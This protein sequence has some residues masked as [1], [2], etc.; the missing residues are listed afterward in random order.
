MKI[1]EKSDE[2]IFESVTLDVSIGRRGLCHRLVIPWL[3]LLP[4]FHDLTSVVFLLSP[5]LGVSQD[6]S[7]PWGQPTVL[8]H[9]R[10]ILD[11]SQ[12]CQGFLLEQG[13]DLHLLTMT[14]FR[15]IRK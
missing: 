9:L 2:K 11:S 5:I 3:T 8:A 10:A 7:P 12:D 15:M 4:S 1:Y 13:S 6:T 14:T